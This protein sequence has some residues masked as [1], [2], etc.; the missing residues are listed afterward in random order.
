MILNYLCG[1]KGVIPYKRIKSYEDLDSVPES[2]FYRMTGFYSSRNY[3]PDEYEN[4]KKID[5]NWEWKSYWIS[6]TSTIFRT[7]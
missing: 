4:V 5:R 2:E 1:G 6:M 3:K 7:Q